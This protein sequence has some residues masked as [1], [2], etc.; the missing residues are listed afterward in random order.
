MIWGFFC[1]NCFLIL[2]STEAGRS[3]L[4]CQTWPLACVS[5]AA[6]SSCPLVVFRFLTNQFIN[7]RFNRSFIA[8]LR[9]VKFST[10]ILVLFTI[11]YHVFQ[12]KNMV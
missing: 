10:S 9:S 3:Y 5:A 6:R 1:L 2:L 11:E 7:S 12:N 8:V 4:G